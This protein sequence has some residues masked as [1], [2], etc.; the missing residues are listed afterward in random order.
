MH[1]EGDYRPHPDADRFPTIV[2][3]ACTEP[4]HQFE[5][6]WSAYVAK[7]QKMAPRTMRRY[8]KILLEMTEF[9]GKTDMAAIGKEDLLKWRDALEN[10]PGLSGVTIRDSYLAAAKALFGWAVL[11]GALSVN[12]AQGVNVTVED[13]VRMRGFT[14][15]E[16]AAILSACLA[17]PGPLM[18]P[19]N[20]SARRWVPWLCAYT[21]ARVNEMTQ[22]RASDVMEH[23]GVWI[24]RISPEAGTVKTGVKRLVALHPHL[25]EMGIV[26]FARAKDG[27]APLFYAPARKRS[28]EGGRAQ[29]ESVGNR[30]ADW[31]RGLGIDDPEVAPNHGWR[32]RYKT[33]RRRHGID[34]E[35]IDAVQGHA[36]ATEGD[37]YGETEV[38]AM[39]REISKLPRY[40][41]EPAAFVD[42]R[43]EGARKLS[44]KPRG[45]RKARR[46]PPAEEARSSKDVATP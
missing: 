29:Y 6:M 15:N 17:P 23:E 21:G 11:K 33:L 38:A 12:P 13:S 25:L 5:A 45:G 26:E 20:A 39:L 37:R 7:K 9:I 24:V 36:P 32:H 31:V 43:R 18:T 4:E 19:E 30:L 22:L 34:K 42:R 46:A 10:R 1:A 14:D 3:P 16:A 8:H 40:E 28:G 35:V 2:R 44:T 41:V 27:D